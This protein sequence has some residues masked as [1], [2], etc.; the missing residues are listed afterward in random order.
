[1]SGYVTLAHDA[2]GNGGTDWEGIARAELE[3]S[4]RLREENNALRAIIRE[5]DIETKLKLGTPL[6]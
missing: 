5:H 2:D 4:A 1:M 3:E 6:A